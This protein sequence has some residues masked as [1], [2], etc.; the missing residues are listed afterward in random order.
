MNI[1]QIE[2]KS[3]FGE[4]DYIIP[5][6]DNRLI[7]VAENGSGKTTI[8]NII[9]F[10][11]TRQW[12]KLLRYNFQSIGATIDND[13][14]TLNKKD[15]DIFS[16]AKIQRYIK[17]YPDSVKEKLYDLLMNIDPFEII[18][19]PYKYEYTADR[20]N[21]PTHIIFELSNILSNEQLSLFNETIP[22]KSKSLSTLIDT[23][24]LYLP[25]YRRIEQD[26]KNIFPDLES[27][28]DKYRRK[29]RRQEPTENSY[30]ELV[31]FG[32]EDVD[33]KIGRRLYELRENLNNKIKNSLAGGYLRDVINKSYQ[34]ISYN[35]IQTFEANAL[36]SILN[37]IDETVLSKQEKTKLLEF[38]EKVNKEGEIDKE[39]NKIIAYFIFRL[40]TIYKELMDEEK[41]I[42]KFISICNE[43]SSNK[44]FVYDNINFS[45]SIHPYI[46]QRIRRR[47]KIEL[48]DLSSG[49]KQIVSLFS[50]IYLSRNQ[51]YF[52][53]IDEPELS[54]SVPWQQRFLLDIVNN[55]YCE[56]I[57]SVT[58]S[59]FIFENELEEYASAL[60]SFKKN[61]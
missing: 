17:R 45:I 59:P 12:N 27:D 55:E 8:V 9:Y 44:K 60:N 46:N 23:Q 42:Q 49:E 20:L 19:S 26:L 15:I 5:I 33:E 1:K 7:L 31:E 2:I 47:E 18:R 52:L 38:A 30:L 54:L 41:D 48:K 24:I 35:Q 25:T 16:S 4:Y 22:K 32:M 11:L 58:H 57:I 10:F 3:L 50:H 13:S 61:K 56:G 43:F 51:N 53:I 39:E 28:V 29:K 40:S 6:K 37:R 34:N 14:F 21:I 36:S